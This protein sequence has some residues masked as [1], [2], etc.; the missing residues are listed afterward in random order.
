LKVEQ[1]KEK[2]VVTKRNK[3][4]LLNLDE[5]VYIEKTGTYS[6]IN[7][8]HKEISV[9]NTLKELENKLPDNFVRAHRSFIINKRMLKELITLNE[10]TYEALFPNDKTALVNRKLVNLIW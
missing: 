10:N 2:L 4:L 5:I 8:L 1:K 3:I 7:T 6:I 9:N